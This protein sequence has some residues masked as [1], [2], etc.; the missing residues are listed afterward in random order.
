MAELQTKLTG[1]S[2]AA[3]VNT[4]PPERRADS[5]RI[6]TMMK[7]VT[8]KKAEMWGPAIVGFGRYHYRSASGREGDWMLTAFSPRKQS[9][10]VYFMSGFKALEPLLKK[11]GKFKRSGG[12]C[13]YI[14][15]LDDIDPKVL[16]KMI[17]TSVQLLLKKQR[18]AQ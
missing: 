17:K 12:G 4:I 8:G 9:L 18:A 7:R 16:E 6:L 2:V 15:K 5:K 11:L 1:K 14:K 3:F 10:T 13:L